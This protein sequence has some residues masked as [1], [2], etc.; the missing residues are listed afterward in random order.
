MQ[1]SQV[2]ALTV[3]GWPSM[4][5]IAR[6]RSVAPHRQ[7]FDAHR[8]P[9]RP[10]QTSKRRSACCGPSASRPPSSPPAGC[11]RPGRRRRAT[12]LMSSATSIA[13]SRAKC[14]CSRRRDERPRAQIVHGHRVLEGL[15]RHA[16]ALVRVR[17]PHRLDGGRRCGRHV[18]SRRAGQGAASIVASAAPS[19]SIRARE[20]GG[21]PCASACATCSGGGSAGS[22]Q[23]ALNVVL[24]RASGWRET[25]DRAPSSLLGA[26]ARQPLRPIEEQRRRIG[27]D[28]EG[29]LRFLPDIH[30][31]RFRAT[32]FRHEHL[33]PRIAL[34]FA[35]ATPR[36]SPPAARCH[37]CRLPCAATCGD[38]ASAQPPR[39]GARGSWR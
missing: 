13:A 27:E 36:P 34:D 14:T 26:S 18:G 19:G 10:A 17:R 28:G 35:W 12:G 11:R 6:C 24:Q 25:A 16:A 2:S 38:A 8:V 33:G 15:R 21:M 32:D 7:A 31:A 30:Q 1:L 39:H 3:S 22:G 29:R 9:H 20:I 23:V 4:D 5:V 37:P